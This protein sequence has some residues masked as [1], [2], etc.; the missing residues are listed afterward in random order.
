V[1]KKQA[2]ISI[3]LGAGVMIAAAV[4]GL[5]GQNASGKGGQRTGAAREMGGHLPEVRPEER[6]LVTSE[7][8]FNNEATVPPQCYTKTEGRHNPCYTCH[9]MYDRRGRDR[10]NQLDDGSLQGGYAFSDEGLE[11]HYTN[12]FVDRREWLAQIEDDDMREYVEKENYRALAPRL[13]KS[14]FQGFIPDLRNYHLGALA[15]DAR[16]LA[17]DGSGWVALNYKPFPGTFWPTNGSTD[18][19][20]VRLPKKFRTSRGKLSEDAYFVNLI[21]VE[22]TMKGVE[23][24]PIW[25]VDEKTL[26]LDV[27]G[28]GTL[29]EARSVKARTNYV[30]DASDTPVQFEQF[31]QGAEIMHSVRYLGLDEKDR[32][33]IPARMKELR[34]MRKVSALSQDTIES[35]YAGERKEKN[36]GNLPHFIYR[37]DEGFDNKLGWYLKGFI[38]DYDGELRPQSLE[39][40]LFC[41]GCHSSI[42]TTIDSTFSFARKLPGERGFGYIDLKGMSD[43]PS[44]SE[45]KG[46]ILR[47]L[48]RV[49]GGSEFRENEEMRAR[50]FREDGSVDTEKVSR[51]DVYTL[52]T[53]SARRA[54]DLNKAYT[55]IVRHQSFI[56]GRD[57]TWSPARKVF[58]SI[59]A[60]IEPLHRDFRFYGWDLRLDFADR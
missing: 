23:S 47:Y 46:E 15:F 14:G 12:L 2:R 3:A 17:R 9:Q 8:I 33:V 51:A 16:G 4:A 49:G 59:D 39:E 22:L 36:Q 42:G 7:R 26:G 6:T 55:H 53:P 52:I 28:D 37:G 41:M 50:W 56:K 44:I 45:T 19:V 5:F 30:G 29:A 43:A 32:T 13:K 20:L 31:P 11:N 10:L 1:N 24:A 21:L 58:A 25:A 54:L 34:Y 38:E 48:E 60:E 57:A 18:D 35:R 40:D 27:D